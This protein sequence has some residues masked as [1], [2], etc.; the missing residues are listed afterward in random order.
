M[1]CSADLQIAI[2]QHHKPK[3][4]EK[5]I[6]TAK[7]E[8]DQASRCRFISTG[9]GFVK[10]VTATLM[11]RATVQ[12]TWRRIWRRQP[13]ASGPASGLP[14]RCS[15]SQVCSGAD[16][17]LSVCRRRRP[18]GHHDQLLSAA[19]GIGFVSNAPMCCL[20]CAGPSMRLSLSAGHPPRPRDGR[21]LSLQLPARM[22]AGMMTLQ[23][24]TAL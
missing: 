15:T 11:E 5:R 19:T 9:A 7:T 2:A 24:S 6:C 23:S 17:S 3:K 10:H 4:T 1:R 18:M 21:F 20:S 14:C 22:E 13:I 12:Y 16:R 8:A